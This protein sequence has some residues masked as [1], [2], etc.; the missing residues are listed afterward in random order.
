MKEARLMR[1]CCANYEVL[2]IAE[3][4][5]SVHS[6]KGV[7][8]HSEKGVSVHFYITYFQQ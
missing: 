4:G 3:K 6:V 5:V 1:L 2:I 8:V 7:S